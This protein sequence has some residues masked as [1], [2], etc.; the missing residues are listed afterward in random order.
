MLVEALKKDSLLVILVT[1][2]PPIISPPKGIRQLSRI[3]F[4]SGSQG[5]KLL[6]QE[7]QAPI[8]Q[9][10]Q[11]DMHP[12]KLLGLLGSGMGF[13]S[14]LQTK[15]WGTVQEPPM[16]CWVSAKKKKGAA[17]LDETVVLPASSR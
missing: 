3:G 8:I 7:S 16:F 11:V 2:I 1:M 17:E 6:H 12:P 15:P 9:I 5:F 4:L 10:L 13:G 14:V